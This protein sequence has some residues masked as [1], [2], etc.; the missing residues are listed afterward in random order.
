MV[1]TTQIAAR[2]V[3]AACG[4][5]SRPGGAILDAV[6][7]VPS[8]SVVRVKRVRPGTVI[9]L[10]GERVKCTVGTYVTR[11]RLEQI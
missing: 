8:G 7:V 4:P 2:A 1:S 3:T 11:S 6:V 9:P 5:S 10:A